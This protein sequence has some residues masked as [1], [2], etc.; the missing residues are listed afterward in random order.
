MR[1]LVERAGPQS[2]QRPPW[3]STHRK[4]GRYQQRSWSGG[5]F[6]ARRGV[7]MDLVNRRK[8]KKLTAS[9]KPRTLFKKCM[10]SI[11]VSFNTIAR[12]AALSWLANFH[13]DQ[14]W[15]DMSCMALIQARV[16]LAYVV[17]LGSFTERN[18]TESLR[19]QTRIN[20]Q[21]IE[22][23]AQGWTSN[24]RLLSYFIWRGSW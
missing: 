23:N 19:I 24:L 15:H 14:I 6:R 2:Y 22:D 9:M 8:W 11:W 5:T 12:T 17:L 16:D 3:I 21:N 7:E 4:T 10:R 18:E 20:P 13:N 1:R